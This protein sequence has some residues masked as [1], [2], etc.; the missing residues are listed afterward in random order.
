MGVRVEGQQPS[1][2]RIVVGVDGSA[3]SKAALAWAVRQADLTG[4]TVEA[5]VA[6]HYPVAVGGYAWVPV[7]ALE[8]ADLKAI[9]VR[10]LSSAIAGIA[11][12]GEH[13]EGQHDSTGRL[14]GPGT[15]GCST[16]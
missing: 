14:R 6:W 3:S 13:S 16:R 15:A 2:D 9:S 7:G 11:D 5:V 1:D 10:K 8:A 12:P 4:G